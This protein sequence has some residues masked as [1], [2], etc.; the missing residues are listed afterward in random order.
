MCTRPSGSVLTVS[1]KANRTPLVPRDAET[2]PLRTMPQP[3][4]LAAWSLP[5]ATTG[6]PAG[7]PVCAAAPA[8]RVPVTSGPSKE[9]GSSAGSMSSRDSSPRCQ[10]RLATSKSRVPEASAM[11]VAYSPVRTQR[12]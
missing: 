2:T 6:M 3:T 1:A 4:P 10:H 12:M 7:R 11:S 8:V 5:P 9:A